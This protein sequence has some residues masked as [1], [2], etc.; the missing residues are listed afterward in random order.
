M[1]TDNERLEFLGDSIL[2]VV[3]AKYLYERYPSQNE[4]FLTKL[5]TKLVNGEALSYLSSELGFGEYIIMSRYI[6]DKCNG[7]KS[8]NILEDVFESFIGSLFLDFNETEID[9][10]MNLYSGIGFHIC[11]KF[12]VNLIEEKVNFEDLISNNTNYKEQIFR[13]F[14]TNY[15]K[16]PQFK[17]ISCTNEDNHKIFTV[18]ILDH[19]NKPI[20]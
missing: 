7:R 18:E 6:E 15:Q 9:T 11:E 8:T 3:I 13:Y 19:E 17:H 14:Q 1:E 4:G 10:H 16:H 12:I 5:R 20:S 2:S